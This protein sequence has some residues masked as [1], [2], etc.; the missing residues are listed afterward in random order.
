MFV[1][2]SNIPENER[3]RPLTNVSATIDGHARIQPLILAFDHAM[4]ES[5]P[6]SFTLFSWFHDIE[7]ACIKLWK[8][9]F[10]R[11]IASD[12]RNDRECSYPFIDSTCQWLWYG[13]LE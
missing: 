4:H 1:I 3:E 2:G 11:I 6:I 8:I 5:N 10:T 9:M 7:D 13:P 12:F